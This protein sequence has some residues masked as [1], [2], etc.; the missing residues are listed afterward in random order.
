MYVQFRNDIGLDERT[1]G[2]LRIAK[3]TDNIVLPDGTLVHT[4]SGSTIFAE[5]IRSMSATARSRPARRSA[6]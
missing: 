5:M 6:P 3:T 1:H 4:A 2:L